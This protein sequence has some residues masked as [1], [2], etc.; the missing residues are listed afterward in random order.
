[1]QD[2]IVIAKKAAGEKAAELI[3]PGM[4]VGLGTG[5]T[6]YWAIQKIGAMVK[7]GLEIRAIATSEASARLAEELHIPLTTFA[8]T[9]Q[10]DMDIDGADE[11]SEQLDVIKGGGGALLREKIVAFHSR[12]LI[13]IAD[14]HKYVPVLGGYPLPIEVIPFGWEVT[15]NRLQQLGC[16][17]LL[18]K[19][20]EEIFITDNGNY[21][22]DCAFGT[23]KD[24]AE[25]NAALHHI[26]GVVETGLFVQMAHTVVL[27]YED[28]STQVLQR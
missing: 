26:P 6:A 28:G 24:P 13:I 10:L 3:R 21:I 8:E 12:Q 27:G 22:I 23:I 9:Q 2:P 18:R 11:I 1:M 20:Q 15:Y 7:Q 19:K 5:S 4:V 25:T 16:K 17:P 14:Q